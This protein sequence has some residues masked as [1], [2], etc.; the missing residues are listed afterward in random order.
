MLYF[1][2]L[3]CVSKFTLEMISEVVV[4]NL[5]T[6][7]YCILT[8]IQALGIYMLQELEDQLDVL[9]NKL[10]FYADQIVSENRRIH[11]E[12]ED[13]SLPPTSPARSKYIFQ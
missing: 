13:Q 4:Q 7:V 1:C 5:I 12:E 8:Q 11:G 9:E 6:I 2:Q 10:M 3:Y